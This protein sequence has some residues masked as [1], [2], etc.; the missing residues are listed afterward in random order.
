MPG[1]GGLASGQS[2]PGLV[3]FANPFGDFGI[4]Q[5]TQLGRLR[6]A[7]GGLGEGADDEEAGL[8]SGR[9]GPV[10]GELAARREPQLAVGERFIGRAE[11]DK[12]VQLRKLQEALKGEPA[13]AGVVGSSLLLASSILYT[14]S[15]SL[16]TASGG[17]AAVG[18]LVGNLVAWAKWLHQ[19]EIFFADIKTKGGRRLLEA[20]ATDDSPLIGMYRQQMLGQL[21]TANKALKTWGDQMRAMQG[22]VQSGPFTAY[23]RQNAQALAVAQRALKAVG[24]SPLGSALRLQAPAEGATG[25]GASLMNGVSGNVGNGKLREQLTDSLNT[26]FRG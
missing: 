9:L 19:A 1:L 13:I 8:R 21:Q 16:A 15:P 3:G 11:T 22:A 6:E 25:L 5:Q 10:A 2:L 12:D 23:L 7:L 18:A 24:S 4:E 20:D 26:L 14:V 17:V